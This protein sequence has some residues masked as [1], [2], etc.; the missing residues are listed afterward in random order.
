MKFYFFVLFFISFITAHG[1]KNYADSLEAFQKNYVAT[2]EVVK[3]KDR[4]RIHFFAIDKNYCVV[5]SFEKK[6]DGSWFQMQTSG[7]IKKLYRVYGVLHFII[8]NT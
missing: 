8:N 6:Q 4:S 7:P 2:H 1:Q 3:G 5:A